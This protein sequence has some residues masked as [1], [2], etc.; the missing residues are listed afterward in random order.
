MENK[1]F[2]P[3]CAEPRAVEK[4]QFPDS[5]QG[6][7]YTFGY[8]KKHKRQRDRAAKVLGLSDQYERDLHRIPV[9][10][11]TIKPDEENAWMSKHSKMHPSKGAIGGGITIMDTPTSIGTFRHLFC[12]SCRE[13]AYVDFDF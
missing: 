12:S 9:T 2:A 11:V 8:C 3:G 6:Y 13:E 1:C 5:N 10:K 7:L 4:R